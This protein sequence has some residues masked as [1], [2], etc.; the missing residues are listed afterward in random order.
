M[1]KEKKTICFPV[2]TGHLFGDEIPDNVDVELSEYQYIRLCRKEI[3]A[4][5]RRAYNE[6]VDVRWGGY[7]NINGKINHPHI[8]FVHTILD[9]VW[10]SGEWVV[11]K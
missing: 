3:K 8:N 5:F 1:F 2:T 6:N 11:K 9:R 4:E 10:N 7:V